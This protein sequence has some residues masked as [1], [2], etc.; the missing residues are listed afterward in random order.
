MKVNYPCKDC[1]DR[2]IGCHSECDKYKDA[3]NKNK[4][5]SE[6]IRKQKHL[7]D[8]FISMRRESIER[9]MRGRR[10]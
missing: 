10:D 5:L 9:V 2:C 6:I 1:T 7:L 3:T 8:L 4:E